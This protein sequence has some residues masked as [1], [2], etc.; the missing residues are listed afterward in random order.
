MTS[1]SGRI[2]AGDLS[3]RITLQTRAAGQDSLGAPVGE[4]ADTFAVW[5]HAEPIRG[6]EY[7]A[8]GQMQAAVDVRFTIRYRADVVETMRVVWRGEPYEIASPPINRDGARD[9]LELM[10]VKGIRDGR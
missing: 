8:S 6:R 3:E 9:V 4:W 7:F 5:A 1:I 2:A 10:C